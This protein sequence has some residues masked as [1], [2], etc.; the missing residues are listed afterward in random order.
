MTDKERTYANATS[1]GML[2]SRIG[3]TLQW[4]MASG[5]TCIQYFTTDGKWIRTEWV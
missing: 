1:K 3:N 4:T 5:Q 2:V